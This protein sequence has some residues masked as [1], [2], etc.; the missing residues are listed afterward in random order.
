MPGMLPPLPS[1]GAPFCILVHT[2]SGAAGPNLT[3]DGFDDGSLSFKE[4]TAFGL[5]GP[6]GGEDAS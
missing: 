4:V 5:Y 3:L 2:G 6:C 1:I